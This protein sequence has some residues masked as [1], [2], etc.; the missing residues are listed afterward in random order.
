VPL[1][2]DLSVSPYFDDFDEAKR[3]H[4]ILFKPTVAVQTRELNQLQTIVQNQIERLGNNLFK[5][6][7]IIDGVNF[8]FYDKYPYVK[9]QDVQISGE[10]AVPEE[11]VGYFIRNDDGMVG[12][13]IDHADGFEP[14]DPNLK[15]LY[16]RYLNSGSSFDDTAFSPGEVLTVYDT[17]NS[18]HSIDVVAGGTGYSNSDVAILTPVLIANVTSGSFDAGDQVQ[19]PITSARGIIVS[20]EDISS[21]LPLHVLPG[22]V[23]VNSGSNVVGTS[24]TFSTSFANGDY[25]TVYSNTTSYDVRKINVVSNNTFMNLTT[26][27]TFANAAATYANTSDSLVRLTYRPVPADLSNSGSTSNNWTFNTGNVVT[28]ASASDV[29]QVLEVVGTNGAAG[30]STDSAGKI[31][32]VTVTNRGSG[33]SAVPYVSVKS[34]SGSSAN[35]QAKNYL[36]QVTVSSL[37]DAVGAGY[38]FGV[39]AGLVYQKGYVVRV[40]P[41]T[42]IVDKYSRHPDDVVVG[43][44]VNEEI[45]NSSID[46]S[47]LDN[48]SGF[49]N[50]TAPGADRL[51]LTANLVVQTV[52]ESEANSEFFTLVEWSEG[53]PFKQNSRTFFNSIEDEMALRTREK[54]GNYV[55]DRFLVTTTAPSNSALVSNSVSVVVDPGTAYIDGHR[56][57]TMANYVADS[58]KATDTKFVESARVSLNYESYVRVKNV[59]GMFEFDRANL[60]SL[61]DSAKS[62]LANTASI[63]A[64]NLAP[65]GN[66][67]G[68]ARTR[69]FILE[70]GIPGTPDAV[71]RLYLFD[72]RMNP[73]KNFRDSRGV[74]QDN[75][76]F[77]GIAD[78]VLSPDATTSSN[79]AVL[80]GNNNSLVFNSGFLSPLSVNNV[81]YTYRTIDDAQEIANTGILTISLAGDPNKTFPYTGTLSDFAKGEIYLAPT[82]NLIAFANLSGTVNVSSSSP[83]VTG[84]GTTFLTD[85]KAGQYVNINGGTS[86]NVIRRVISVT[87][88]SLLT[89]ESNCSFTDVSKPIRKAWPAY[90]PVQLSYNSNIVVNTTTSDTVLNINLGTTLSSTS[91]TDVVV[92]YNV[93]SD[94][95]SPT[96]KVPRRNLLVKLRIANNE[97]GSAG[98]WCLGVPDA[99]R[100]RNVYLGNSAVSSTSTNVTD[101]FFIDNNHNSNYLNHSYLYRNRSSSVGLTNDDYLLVEFDAYTASPGFYNVGSYVSSNKSTRFTE[102]AKP[103]A[104]LSSTVNTFEIPEF[105]DDAG[106]YHDLIGSVDFRPYV[107][108]TANVTSNTSLVTTNPNSAVSF[109]SADRF[110]PVP[111]SIYQH[112]VEYFTPRIDSIVLDK[113]SK[114]SIVRGSQDVTVPAVPSG[115]IRLNNLA[116]PSYPALPQN[117]NRTILDLI[118][119][120][121]HSN[122]YSSPR[123]DAKRIKTLFTNVDFAKEQPRNWTQYD[124]GEINRRL[125]NVEYYV[126]LNSV[127]QGIKDRVIPSSV[128]PNIDRFKYGFFVDDYDNFDLSETDSPEYNASIIDS[129]AW[130][131]LTAFNAVHDGDLTAAPYTSV[132]LV[133]QDNAT[134]ED[135]PPPP[136]DTK[137]IGTLQIIPPFFKTQSYTSRNIQTLQSAQ[138]SSAG[139]STTTSTNTGKKS[140]KIV[141]TAMNE[142]YGFGSFRQTI[143]LQHAATLDPAYERGYHTI[144]LPVVDWLYHSDRPETLAQKVVRTVVERVARKRTADI[145]KQRKGGIDL[146]G[147]IYRTI[148]EPLCFLVGKIKG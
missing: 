146:E 36:A 42:I 7:T 62:F 106:R 71:Y 68:E 33:Y 47:L 22:T 94:G 61:Y 119:T 127:Q 51:K 70:Q 26:N 2:T 145:W 103:L 102:D 78:V 54:D 46:T 11:Y 123:L 144:F 10:L 107:D 95:A 6:G 82:A 113:N 124:I 112:D 12:Y 29:M 110:F 136:P 23:A 89:L 73:G 105:F 17:N 21:R 84:N 43:F 129:Y 67:I 77:D 25:I 18:I 58:P 100:L 4:R 134:E 27:V 24:T 120:K 5:R 121:V 115:T 15:T 109:S 75:T 90:V 133:S 117:V 38:A 37:A 108:A 141:C 111:D 31:I 97:G 34:S 63:A 28:G 64:G 19:D 86:N 125:E 52:L 50:E 87:N 35:L 88:N 114:V 8:I 116:I 147:R 122:K 48:S 138:S 132:K 45:I 60:V 101:E 49:N 57:S 104:N 92:A 59:G 69:N 30:I 65:T 137:Y 81:S 93:F 3:F 148:L 139:T 44:E 14:T 1:E 20:S 128:S 53:Y 96:P 39:T 66:K 16:I 98:P 130:P 55:T 13:V 40:E 56:V 126:L 85:I 79:V 80:V 32:T 143:W 135:P 74:W 142:A 140:K 99:F 72:I 9:I 91:N 118:N 41:Q 76:T 83:N 131:A